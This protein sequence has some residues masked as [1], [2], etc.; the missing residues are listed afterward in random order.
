MNLKR[1]L[2]KITVAGLILTT[3]WPNFVFAQS[4]FDPNLIISDSQLQDFSSWGISD[5]QNFLDA[6]GSYLRNYTTATASG[7]VKSAA[8]IIYDSARTYQINPKYIL[9][10]LQKEQSLVTDDSPT[11]KQLDWATGYAVCDSCS[12]DD[13]KIQSKKGFA[14]QVENAAGIMR[15]YYDHTTHPVVKQKDR[16]I[17]IDNT[18]VVPQSWA[19]AFL[20]TYTPHLHGNQNFKRIWDTWFSQVYPDG[21]LLKNA[22]SSE[23][24]LIQNGKKRKFASMSALVSRYDPKMTI[25]VPVAE[26]SNYQDGPTINLSNY[27]ILKTGGGRYYLLDYDTLRPFE[28]EAVVG[29]LGYNP[30]EIVD[31]ADAD[32]ADYELG[33]TIT[34][35]TA[36]PLGAIYQITDAGDVYY[37]L[38]NNELRPIVDRRVIDINFKNLKIEKHLRA[39]L[40]KFNIVYD[41]VNYKD[42]TLVRSDLGGPIYVVAGGQKRKISDNETFRAFGY[43]LKNVVVAPDTTL[44]FL[45]TGEP[46]YLNASLLSAREKYL[47][48]SAATVEDLFATNLP[49]YLVAEYPSGRILS[50]KN[51]DTIRSIASLTKLITAYEAIN[52][53]FDLEK[54][55]TYSKN[56]H[57]AYGNLLNLAEGETINNRDLLGTMLI[58]SVNNTARMVASATNLGEEGVIK[59]ANER[60]LLWGADNSK[61]VDTSGLDANNKSTARDLLKIFTKILDNEI[62]KETLSKTEYS[63]KEVLNKNKVSTHKFKNSNYL[64][65]A[66][67]LNYK[68][69]ASK[70]GYTSEAGSTLIMLLENKIDKQQ[71]TIITMG[72]PNYKNR[73]VEP[74]KIARWVIEKDGDLA[75]TKAIDT[76]VKSAVFRFDKNL[77][78][79]DN[80]ED[81]RQ[82]QL[83]LKKLGYFTYPTATGKFGAI[84]KDAV[85]KFQKAKKLPAVGIVGPATR[86]VLNKL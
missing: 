23:I 50:G 6:R 46:L 74:D 76:T 72:G 8:E 68:I 41:V 14:N 13:P 47:G 51:I 9:V 84:T 26:L 78:N 49:A 67:G 28:S 36:A 22:S 30:G 29:K 81:V 62:L 17:F 4:N 63:F 3:I 12:M 64:T 73:F 18:P 60:L 10:T 77:K 58:A 42:G 27:S 20:Y 33:A 70:T 37:L 11:Q 54:T 69:L 21:S 7:A 56:K 25:V 80:N 45:K 79:G 19:T 59:S 71:Y 75:G 2:T 16:S 24:Y 1:T 43:D 65:Y 82:L 66:K 39:D 55:T 85:V 34:A 44:G 31:I 61:I 15:W 35:S 53:G 38:K 40:T 5:V 32:T 86:A 48:D 57:E 52:N 83:T